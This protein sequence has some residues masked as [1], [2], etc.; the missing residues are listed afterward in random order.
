MARVLQRHGLGPQR[1]RAVGAL[2]GRDLTA[3]AGLLPVDA[4]RAGPRVDD[5]RLQHV[6]RADEGG[7]EARAR[8]VVDLE[9]RAELLDAALAHDH[10]PVR[11]GQGLLLVVG[12]EDGGD[13]EGALQR[14]QL[15]AQS[16][17]HLG[18]ERG[19]GL[20]EQQ[21]LRPGRERAGQR[22]ALL[23]AAG[24]LVG[25]AVGEG[26]ELHDV[27]HGGDALARLRGGRLG[28]L[29]PEGD[30]ARHRHVGEQR[31]V[32]E[33]HA[34][35]PRARRQVRDVAPRDADRA[36]TR[37]LEAGD[38]AKRRGLAAARGAEEG[39]ELA[40]RHVKVEALHHLMVAV[41]LGQALDRQ[42]AH[43]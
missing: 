19:Q 31:V 4:D 32:L 35:A 33:H 12:D 2:R 14:L 18:V 15:V 10:D 16:D 7:H 1:Q 39:D 24:D 36:R 21:Q 42:E 25:I 40:G 9:R 11:H 29:E 6:Q 3:D 37:A 8:P 20:V 38:H 22:H 34:D 27:Q 23:L 26:A 5:A 30:V 43:G 28:D 13:A 41:A 17:A